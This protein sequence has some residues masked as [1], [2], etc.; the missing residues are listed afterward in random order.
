MLSI[1]E[2]RDIFFIYASLTMYISM[3]FE[4]NK[5][6]LDSMTPP[7]TLSVILMYRTRSKHYPLDRTHH[8]CPIIYM[9]TKTF[10]ADKTTYVLASSYLLKRYSFKSLSHSIYFLYNLAIE[11]LLLGIRFCPPR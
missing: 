4:L 3:S 5:H 7:S 8:I 9:L 6:V 1:G 2:Y 10:W 11:T